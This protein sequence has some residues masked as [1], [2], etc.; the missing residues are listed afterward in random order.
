MEAK[1][2]QTFVAT[3]YNIICRLFIFTGQAQIV[4]VGILQW[5][6]FWYIKYNRELTIV[7]K[8]RI[9]IYNWLYSSYI[10]DQTFPTYII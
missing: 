9:M 4:Q 6:E 2:R 3:I 7:I 10:Y 5:K 8:D 1:T